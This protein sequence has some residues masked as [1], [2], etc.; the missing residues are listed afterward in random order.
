[1]D[2][3]YDQFA[4]SILDANGDENTAPPTVWYKELTKPQEF[5][6]DTAQVFLG[7]RMACAQCHHHPY[8]KWS[9]DDYWNLAAFFGRIGRT[10]VPLVGGLANQQ[11]QMQIIFNAPT[12]QVTNQR[13]NKPAEYIP[14]DAKEPMKI[15]PTDDPRAK[16]VDWMTSPTNPYFARTVANRY[17]AH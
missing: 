16:L 7:L 5:V 8:E 14:L 3:P 10:N 11:V 1:K 4:R 9:Q 2:M 13:T 15:E 12:G 17:W 6:D